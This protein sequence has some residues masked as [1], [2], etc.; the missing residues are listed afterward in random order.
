MILPCDHPCIEECRHASADYASTDEG[1]VR[2]VDRNGGQGRQTYRRIARGHFN[3]IAVHEIAGGEHDG[4]ALQGAEAA[5]QFGIR[6]SRQELESRP[7]LE[8]NC[9]GTQSV[10]QHPV[11]GRG[12]SHDDHLPGRRMPAQR[13]IDRACK[14]VL[15]RNSDDIGGQRPE[16]G[17]RHA[18]VYDRHA[19]EQRTAMR[20]NEGERFRTR[21]HDDGWPARPVLHAQ[22][23][24][25][26]ALEIRTPEPG[27]VE[28][29]LEK[30]ATMLCRQRL[31][32]AALDLHVRGQQA[33]VGEQH[34]H[35]RAIGQDRCRRQQYGQ[36][37]YGRHHRLAAAGPA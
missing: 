2:R 37:Q 29:L 27:C 26:R 9:L 10:F 3:A 28:E 16:L 36:Q 25:R 22:V 21:S 32:Q 15:D 14:I 6:R 23:V 13:L 20:E 34:Q 11:A 7:W 12:A 18:Q 24:D 17:A 8:A 5:D 4:I 19:G 31:A 33:T 1:V 30:A 35:A